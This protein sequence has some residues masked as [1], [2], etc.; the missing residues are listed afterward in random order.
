MP[1]TAFCR[2]CDKSHVRPVGRNC[3]KAKVGNAT[4]MAVSVSGPS[5]PTVTATPTATNRVSD[6]DDLILQT[7]TSINEKLNSL[8]GRVRQTESA[9]ADR[10]THLSGPSIN[11][12]EESEI[13]N[14]NVV[15]SCPAAVSTA[16]VPT[17][18]YLRSNTDIQRQVDARFVELQNAQGPQST[19]RKLKSRRGGKAEVPIRRFVAWPQHYVLI[20]SDKRRP[21]F[22]ELDST[23]FMAGCIKG[24]LDLPEPDRTS[25]LKYLANLLED[26]SDFHF[27][28]AKACHAVVLTTMEQD[29]LSWQDTH[30]LDR[31]RRQHAQKHDTPAR[32]TNSTNHKKSDSAPGSRDILCKFYNDSHC[33][34]QKSHLTKG[35]WY[36]HLCSKCRGEHAAKKCPGPK[37]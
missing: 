36:I 23:K 19:S 9:L 13:Q 20:G 14:S 18:E 4:A 11:V 21:T 3:K 26:A 7:L 28:N 17:T 24:A 37:N 15:N 32:Q 33:S 27:D 12:S 8:D 5:I 35:T 29:Q 34:R 25:N 30:E 31:F 10:T 16:V 22:D 2:S 6:K 1:A